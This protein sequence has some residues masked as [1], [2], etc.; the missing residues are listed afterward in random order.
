MTT[1]N[2]RSI[3]QSRFPALASLP[4]E[5]S[6]TESKVKAVPGKSRYS[7]GSSFYRIL[8]VLSSIS[9]LFILWA[10]RGTAGSD[11]KEL[12]PG[13]IFW[14]SCIAAC[15][16]PNIVL[17]VRFWYFRQSEFHRTIKVERADDRRQDLIAYLFAMLLPF[18][19]VD[20][21][22]WRN[23]AATLAALV[24][25]IVLFVSLNM[26]YMNFFFAVLGYHCFH[27]TSPEEPGSPSSLLSFMLITK[28]D[29]LKCGDTVTGYD[30]DPTLLIERER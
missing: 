20:L 13:A 30:I 7:P 26:S 10:I 11:G 27:V 3:P 29:Q 15:L 17:A 1:Q 12:I 22:S 6:A 23:F 24:I 28:R 9:P 16:I 8:L 19:T 21:S 25:V 18:Y 4:V 2:Q 5:P 14:M